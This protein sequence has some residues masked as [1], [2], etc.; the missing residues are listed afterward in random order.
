MRI[1]L[2]LSNLKEEF[3]Q[4]VRVGASVLNSFY[5]KSRLKGL[6]EAKKKGLWV[7]LDSGAFT[8]WNKN[9]GTD[10]EVKDVVGTD[11][12]RSVVFEQYKREYID[13]LKKFAS[14]VDVYVILDV[15]FDPERTW[16]IWKEM[17]DE[18]L[19][20]MPVVHY[21]ADY[22]YIE[23][24]LDEGVEYLGIGRLACGRNDGLQ[25]I[26]GVFRNFVKVDGEG[27]P[28]PK[29]HFFAATTPEY[30]RR[31]PLY[32]AD[33]TTWKKAAAYG[34]IPVPLW[35]GKEFSFDSV[36][37]VKVARDR[38]PN[39]R[40]MCF[41]DYVKMVGEDIV[42]QIAKE[43]FD[44]ELGVLEIEERL[45]HNVERGKWSIWYYKKMEEWWSR[46]RDWEVY[47]MQRRKYFV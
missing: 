24:Y 37:R 18:G 46:F 10:R 15:I 31:Y 23:K 38:A 41:M 45:Q 43:V 7:M 25:W 16:E 13:W 26:D 28:Y 42:K 3:D 12:S 22:R 5:E 6:L 39:D 21:G 29:V 44:E 4:M 19:D 8:W 20:P 17:K 47:K 40:N 32:S 27:E 30:F 33:S 36:L 1:V 14:D 11:W 34:C 2:W 9:V 35:T